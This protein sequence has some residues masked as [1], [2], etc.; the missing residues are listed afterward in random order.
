MLLNERAEAD[1][2]DSKHSC[3][4]ASNKTSKLEQPANA[5]PA[6]WHKAMEDADHSSIEPTCNKHQATAKQAC[7]DYASSLNILEESH[8]LGHGFQV[9]ARAAN[10]YAKQMAIKCV[11]SDSPDKCK[12]LLCRDSCPKGGFAEIKLKPVV[13]NT[14]YPVSCNVLPGGANV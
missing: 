1:A 3:S 10:S 11:D 14:S 6:T 8:Q 4:N 7:N 9:W 2:K 5:C 12:Q 13:G